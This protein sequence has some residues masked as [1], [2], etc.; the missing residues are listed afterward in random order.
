MRKII[1]G[2]LMQIKEGNKPFGK[3]IF[4]LYRNSDNIMPIMI[5]EPLVSGGKAREILTGIK[6]DTTFDCLNMYTS[7][8]NSRR[9]NTFVHLDFYYIGEKGVSLE[10]LAEYKLAHYDVEKY[11]KELK[12]IKLE[13]KRRMQMFLENERQIK[14]SEKKLKKETKQY[15]KQILYR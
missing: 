4:N 1:I 10:E 3:K 2:N 14:A 12:E 15:I 6:F 7:Y 5:E 9:I 8:S 13:G 11:K